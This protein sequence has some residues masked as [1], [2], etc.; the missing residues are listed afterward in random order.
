MRKTIYM[1]EFI[2]R[3]NRLFAKS[4]YGI[5]DFMEG[6]WID[7]NWQFTKGGDCLYWIPPSCIN[8]VEKQNT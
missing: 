3:G 7:K 4:E 5:A 2:F 1:C 8:Y 6:F